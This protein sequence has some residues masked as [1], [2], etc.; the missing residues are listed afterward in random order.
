MSHQVIPQ[1]KIV[2]R[3]DTTLVDAYLTPVLRH[4]INQVED[5]LSG[6]PLQFMQSNG[7][8][9]KASEFSGCN[10]ILSGPAGGVVG[11]VA[12]AKALGFDNIIGFDMGG[13]STDIC[14]YKGQYQ[15]TLDTEIAG[16][17]ISAPM[18]DIH[19]VAA[20]GGSI[21]HYKD[22]RFQVG[23]DS[24]GANPGPA[25][26]QRGGPLTVTDIQVLLGRIRPDCFPSCFCETSDQPLNKKVVTEA[27]LQLASAISNQTDEPWSSQRVGQ[28]FMDIAVANMAN[29]IKQMTTS[30]GL[31]VEDFIINCFGGA[32]GQ[33][34]CKV[35]EQLK[36]KKILIHPMAS[37]LS[38][39][40]MGQADTVIILQQSVAVQLSSQLQQRVA[41]ICEKL[42]ADA[43]HK[44]AVQG[45]DQPKLSYQLSLRYK[46]SDNCLD[47]DYHPKQQENWQLKRSGELAIADK[48]HQQHQLMYGFAEISKPIIIDKITVEARYQPTPPQLP[49]WCPDD[50]KPSTHQAFLDGQN[51]NITFQPWSALAEGDKVT[52]PIII[53]SE[54]TTLVVEANWKAELKSGGSL[55]LNYQKQQKH[56]LASKQLEQDPVRLELFS[57]LYR[58]VAEQMGNVLART[59]HSVNIK[60]RLDFSCAIFDNQGNLIANAPHMPVHLG[61]MGESICSVLET[62]TDMKDGDVYLINDPYHGGTHLPDMTVVTPVF[63]EHFDKHSN[64]RRLIYLVASRGHHADVGGIS[65]GSM[66]SNSTSIKQEGCLFNCFKLVSE[67]Q[68]QEAALLQIL[69]KGPYPARNPEQNIADLKAQIAANNK[70]RQELSKSFQQY[71]METVLQYMN[72]VQD[73]AEQ[74]VRR[75]ISKLHNGHYCYVMDNGAE[76]NVHIT[77]DQDKGKALVDFEGTSGQLVSNF[78][79][80]AAISR[81]AVLYVF[82]CLVDEDIPLNGGCLRPIEIRIPDNSLLNPSFPAAVVAGNVET[83]QCITDALFCALGVVAGSQGTMNNLT[84]GNEHYQYYETIAG[85]AGATNNFDGASGVQTHMTN[86]RITDP[87]ILERRFPVLL[88]QYGYRKSSG[89]KGFKTGGEGLYREIG[90]LEPMTLNLLSGNRIKTPPGLSGGQDGK[91]GCNQLF[92]KQGG[93]VSLAGNCQINVGSGDKILIKT[94]GGGGF[95]HSVV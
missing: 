47:I 50:S 6:A 53:Y 18:L 42:K 65:P 70:G 89:G 88:W 48:F 66:P 58:T 10:S 81:A 27:F 68:F 57:N 30:K 43:Q 74:I 82:R 28:G 94:P 72:F 8:L 35:A 55:L 52:G 91:V 15:Q 63:D 44:M 54:Y 29:A 87:E 7:G 77:I 83:S 79:A 46:G 32:G 39:F 19:T 5:A 13:T 17:R 86:S 25:S 4:Y 11:M 24:A 9:T 12:T 76:I 14:L 49:K 73:N 36:I 64:K 90:F 1:I 84:F 31:D 85:G 37:L 51:Q 41:Q 20:G 60:E 22:Q 26:Y 56:D 93:A 71:T 34:A 62:A 38:A 95:G 21:I 78:N 92:K 59:A 16:V 40:G 80:P 33:H 67:G 75:V 45:I 61:S 23:P 2:A 3:G 69:T